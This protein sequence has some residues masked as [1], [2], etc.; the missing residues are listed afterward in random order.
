MVIA[1]CNS[2]STDGD[3]QCI[4]TYMYWLSSPYNFMYSKM[5]MYFI[6]IYD[7]TKMSMNNTFHVHVLHHPC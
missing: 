6:H 5:F 7:V 3:V 2:K 1:F 4:G